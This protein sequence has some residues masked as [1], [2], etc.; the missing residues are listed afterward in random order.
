MCR[1]PYPCTGLALF[2]RL[3]PGPDS[4]DRRGIPDLRAF[5]RALHRGSLGNAELAAAD[6]GMVQSGDR[7][8]DTCGSDGWRVTLPVVHPPVQRRRRALPCGYCGPQAMIRAMANDMERV[9]WRR[10]SRLCC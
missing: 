5:G 7:D 6:G 10:A 8:D 3:L 4:P 2:D 1:V 9:T